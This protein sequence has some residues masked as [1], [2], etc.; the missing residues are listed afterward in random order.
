MRSPVCAQ[1][2]RWDEEASRRST[3]RQEVVGIAGERQVEIVVG[4]VDATA[5]RLDCQRWFGDQTEQGVAMFGVVDEQGFVGSQS[6]QRFQMRIEVSDDVLRIGDLHG[7]VAEQPP[8]RRF[9][10]AL[11]A[12]LFFRPQAERYL[13][14]DELLQDVR[15]AL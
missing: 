5:L 15:F 6:Q 10:E 4:R 13:A 3:D 9:V 1:P 14:A 2:T 8:H 7:V 11:A 12:T